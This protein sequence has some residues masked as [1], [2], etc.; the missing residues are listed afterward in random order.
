MKTNTSAVV[1]A[2]DGRRITVELEEEFWEALRDVAAR[3]NTDLATLVEQLNRRRGA[4]SLTTALRMFAIAYYR[5]AVEAQEAGAIL[6][7]AN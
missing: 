4:D 1:F 7:R 3:Q 5:S 2:L 6:L